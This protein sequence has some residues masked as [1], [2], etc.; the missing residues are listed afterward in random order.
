MAILVKKIT[1]EQIMDMETGRL[2]NLEKKF[3]WSVE[4]NIGKCTNIHEMLKE[5]IRNYAIATREIIEVLINRLE[6][7][8]LGLHKNREFR[9]KNVA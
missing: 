7:R 2:G 9:T 6:N 5:R 3:V 4:L 1:P 8:G